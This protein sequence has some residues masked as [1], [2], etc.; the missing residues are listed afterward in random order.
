M[1]RE[2]YPK[3]HKNKTLSDNKAELAKTVGGSTA[4]TRQPPIDVNRV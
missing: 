4:Y 1:A 3:F 2:I